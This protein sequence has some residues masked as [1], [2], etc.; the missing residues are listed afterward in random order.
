[1]REFLRGWWRWLLGELV[2]A[3][4][5]A[6]AL[7]LCVV[8]LGVMALGAVMADG[9]QPMAGFGIMIVALILGSIGFYRL[10]R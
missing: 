9:G 7:L 8:W 6:L 3:A 5:K 4:L 2:G 1:M 10:T